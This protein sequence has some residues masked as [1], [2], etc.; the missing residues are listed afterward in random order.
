MRPLRSRSARAPAPP[1]PSAAGWLRNG[2]RNR[3]AGAP[4][5]GNTRPPARRARAARRRH[6]DQRAPAEQLRFRL[7]F[8]NWRPR[9]SMTSGAPTQAQ[10]VQHEV[11][12][13]PQQHAQQRRPPERP[14][15][16]RRAQ[17]QVDD[18]ADHA[19]VD[20]QAADRQA[21]CDSG[22]KRRRARKRSRMKA[23]IASRIAC[24]PSK[25]PN[26]RSAST[27]SRKA[28]PRPIFSGSS[29]TQYASTKAS[30]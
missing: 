27:P 4:A 11:Q 5:G 10:R 16:L 14:R 26:A 24:S 9:R 7:W 25:P 13:R 20:Q 19:V 21:C 8:F 12:R 3:R 22:K 6:A 30:Q 23:K 1:P 2:W 29:S 15:M 28:T 18:R 17:H